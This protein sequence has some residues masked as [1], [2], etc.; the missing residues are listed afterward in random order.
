MADIVQIE[1]SQFLAGEFPSDESY[2]QRQNQEVTRLVETLE[3]LTGRN[4]SWEP[5]IEEFGFYHLLLPV[6]LKLDVPLYGK[7]ID[8]LEQLVDEE[9]STS[10]LHLLISF[11]SR[12]TCIYWSRYFPPNLE[13]T[14]SSEAT[15][16]DSAEESLFEQVQQKLEE[17][18]WI[19]LPPAEAAEIVPGAPPPWPYKEGSALVRHIIFPGCTVL[20]D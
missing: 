9:R 14:I 10:F 13:E 18:G 4:I 19:W 5:P 3:Q 1:V 12:F 11:V 17:N 7:T 20:M 16:Q 6:D 15:F 2:Y 8:L